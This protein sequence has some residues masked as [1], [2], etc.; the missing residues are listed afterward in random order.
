MHLSYTGWPQ[1]VSLDQL[2]GQLEVVAVEE[3][4]EKKMHE[5]MK[6]VKVLAH[7]YHC[8]IAIHNF[9]SLA[10]REAKT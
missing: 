1:V 6:V 5:V 9:P 2:E 10:S 7:L 8:S 3:E 4:E